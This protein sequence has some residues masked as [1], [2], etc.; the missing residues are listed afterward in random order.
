MN[1]RCFGGR[2]LLRMRGKVIT[3][4][5]QQIYTKESHPLTGVSY[6]W[7]RKMQ[8]IKRKGVHAEAR[9]KD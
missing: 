3:R 7:H 6:M 4:N 8:E 1:R 5:F 9:V 2:D